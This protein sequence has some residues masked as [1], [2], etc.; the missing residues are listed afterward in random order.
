MVTS[1]NDRQI[2]QIVS[3]GEFNIAM[4]TD[5]L[6]WGWGKNEHGQVCCIIQ[7]FVMK[8]GDF[9]VRPELN[10]FVIAVTQHKCFVIGRQAGRL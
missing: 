9:H 8:E 4:D 7:V 10:K 2:T 5:Y 3:G 6:I 1:I